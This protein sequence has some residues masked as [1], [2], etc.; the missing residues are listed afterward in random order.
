MGRIF[1]FIFFIFFISNAFSIA[2]T[3]KRTS[4]IFVCSKL[5]D[6]ELLNV[7]KAT[8]VRA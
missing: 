8:Q 1:F 6:S 7:N 4:E 3:F 5:P 2:C